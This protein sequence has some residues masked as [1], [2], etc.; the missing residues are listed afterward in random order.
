MPKKINLLVF[1]MILLFAILPMVSA[2][3]NFTYNNA[4][5]VAG[6][7]EAIVY[8]GLNGVLLFLLVG[9]FL[10]FLNYENLLSKVSSVGVGYLLL[11][12]I[13][14][15]SWQMASD[16]VSSYYLVSIFKILFYVLM[17]GGFPLLLGAFAWYL[18]MLF[19]IKEIKRLMGK[20]FSEDEARRRIR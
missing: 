13:S 6:T 18:I 17:I 2:E 19:K 12:A 15:I 10:I 20:G 16:F 9:C 5:Y 14:F 4:T 3:S 1:C 11:I 8:F 7:G